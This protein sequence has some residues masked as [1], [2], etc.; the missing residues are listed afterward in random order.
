MSSAQPRPSW[1]KA[2]LSVDVRGESCPIPEM[3]ASKRLKELP[4]AKVLEVITDHQPSV[5][6]TLPDLAREK[7]YG[8]FA[9]KDG[10]SYRVYFSK[11]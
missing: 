7:G 11:P 10:D 2:D 6:V 4:E 9:E 1:A 3:T 5:D 8:F